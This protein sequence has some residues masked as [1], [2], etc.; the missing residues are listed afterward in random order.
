[1]HENTWLELLNNYTHWTPS[2]N[3]SPD[4]ETESYQP[5]GSPPPRA[6]FS[7]VTPTSPQPL[8]EEPVS[9]FLILQI[10]LTCLGTLCKWNRMVRSFSCS[11]VFLSTLFV[12]TTPSTVSAEYLFAFMGMCLLINTRLFFCRVDTC[13]SAA[14]HACRRLVLTDT[15]TFLKWLSHILVPKVVYKMSVSPYPHQCRIFLFFVLAVLKDYLVLSNCGFNM[16]F[17]DD[18]VAHLLHVYWQFA[19][20][21]LLMFHFFFFFFANSWFQTICWTRILSQIRVW[22]ISSLTLL[23]ASL[24]MSSF[25]K[26][27]FIVVTY[28]NVF[29]LWLVFCAS[30][31]KTLPGSRSFTFIFFQKL[32]C[33]ACH[34][35]RSSI[36]LG[37][38]FI[39]C[40]SRGQNTICF[41]YR[42]LTD[43]APFIENT[44]LSPLTLRLD[45]VLPLSFFLAGT[46]S[47]SYTCSFLTTHLSFIIKTC[48]LKPVSLQLKEKDKHT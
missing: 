24:L 39:P 4:L 7:S 6:T 32:Y 46:L 38:I 28:S 37:L 48:S 43:P 3:Q 31:K 21:F 41:L 30:F 17:F 8:Q 36:H 27:K 18:S 44:V 5:P 35:F 33:F 20:S 40:I 42:Y 34:T 9:G 23:V 15:D 11:D 1:M 10:S 2:F 26:W 22:Q 25:D 14:S 13:N 16:Y 12:R 45:F 47:I 29:I 19:Y